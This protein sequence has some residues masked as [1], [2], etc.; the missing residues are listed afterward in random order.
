MPPTILR[1]RVRIARRAAL[2]TLPLAVLITAGTGLMLSVSPLVRTVPGRDSGVF[3]YVASVILDGGLPY[4]DVWDHKPPAIY[5]LDALGL[6][7]TG[8]SLWGVWIVQTVFV[9]S[10]IVLG[11]TLM[12]KAFGS[13]PAFFGSVAWISTLGLLLIWENY[14]EEYALPLQFGSLYLLH[15]AEM[16]HQT[17]WRRLLIMGAIGMLAA[18]SFLLKPT[19]VG[20]HISIV[21]LLLF[22]GLDKARRLLSALADSGSIFTGAV[23]VL[24]PTTV[25]FWSGGVMGLAFDAVF[26]YNFF[27][28]AASSG[29]RLLSVLSGIGGLPAL[30]G[31]PA[32][33]LLAWAALCKDILGR[34]ARNRVP[35]SPLYAGSGRDVISGAS[36]DGGRE[37]LSMLGLI[38][39]PIELL[40]VATP[41]RSYGYYYTAWLPIIGILCALFACGVL[42]AGESWTLRSIWAPWARVGC[43]CA[44]LPVL[45]GIPAVAISERIS[46]PVS[47][48]ATRLEAVRYITAHTSAAD[49]VLIW[50][51]EPG[52]NFVAQRSSPTR[53]VYQYPLFTRGYSDAALIRAFLLDIESNQPAL[54]IDASSSDK[55]T[56]PLEKEQR[57]QWSPI[58]VYALPVGFDSVLHYLS[59]NYERV[60]TLEPDGWGTYARKPPEDASEK[61][62]FQRVKP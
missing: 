33:A 1:A 17:L 29:G 61:L 26:R 11:F 25:Y 59:T 39:F 18:A 32:L 2:R 56:P 10:A 36:G 6:A 49:R 14:P 34:W 23:L 13:M 46:A 35:A 57:T 28:L 16:S 21:A 5:Y 52:V 20:T 47:T 9:C 41:G 53:F 42:S 12:R 19:L 54:I 7:L 43:L 44:F 62:S 24:V 51:A 31:A 8:R 58:L 50:G 48:A 3:L 37:L 30:S 15:K 45:I 22:R 4:R 55:I 27:Y 38:A 40:L 60:G